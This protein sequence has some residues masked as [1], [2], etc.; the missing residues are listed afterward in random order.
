MEL[1]AIALI[2]RQEMRV[3]S[4]SR[5]LVGFAV[6]FGVL[7]LAI[8]YFGAVTAGSVG[9]QGFERTA[10]S[11]V[12][13][14][15]YLVPLLGLMLAG[16]HISTE[17]AEN[18]L[19]F[20]QPVSRRDILFG[21]LAGMFVTMSGAIAAGFG[22]SGG[23]ILVETGSEG[24]LRFLGVIALTLL[25]TAVFLAMGAAIG[26]MSQSRAQALGAALGAW[27]FFVIFYD[28]AVMGMTFVLRERTANNMIFLSL[29]GNPVG[30]A[31]VLSLT[32]LSDPAIFGPAG[33]A[34]LKYLGGTVQAYSAL[35]LGLCA[36]II[37]PL[38]LAARMIRRMDL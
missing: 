31:R 18:E 7:S 2:A 28:L 15:L 37:A 30:L 21:R 33:A 11:L 38:A 9:I 27:F 17:R 19:L 6:V 32:T 24:A 35:V 23:V 8:A 29:F 22:L 13:L 16:F 4:R 3:C 36:W 5:W 26:L 14:V 1:N 20:S 12:S 34:L 25:L 10:A